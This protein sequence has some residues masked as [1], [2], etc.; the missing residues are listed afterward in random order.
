M[1]IRGLARHL[2]ELPCR[3]A[4]LHVLIHPTSRFLPRHLSFIFPFFYTS[5]LALSDNTYRHSPPPRDSRPFYLILITGTPE[6][7][8]TT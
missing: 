4:H 7:A 2:N 5:R 6:I 8:S 1:D 3:S